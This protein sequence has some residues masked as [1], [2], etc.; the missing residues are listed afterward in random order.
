MDRPSAAQQVVRKAD[1]THATSFRPFQ[2]Q[3][4]QQGSGERTATRRDVCAGLRGSATRPPS[5]KVTHAPNVV[6]HGGLLRQAHASTAGEGV[7]GV[8]V[9]VKPRRV[10]ALFL[11]RR[12]LLS[13]MMSYHE[14]HHCKSHFS[15]MAKSVRAA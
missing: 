4:V 8:H 13:V 2:L 7:Q 3:E 5:Q 1:S 12:Q 14:I 15:K 10:G 11:R 9:Y 6:P